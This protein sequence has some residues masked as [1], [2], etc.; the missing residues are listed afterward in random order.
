MKRRAA[1]AIF[2]GRPGIMTVPIRSLKLMEC[3][4]GAVFAVDWP[5]RWMPLVL[6]LGLSC[7]VVGAF[8]LTGVLPLGVGLVLLEAGAAELILGPLLLTRGAWLSIDLER[9]WVHWRRR[10]GQ[11]LLIDSF[12][13]GRLAEVVVSRAPSAVPLVPCWQVAL[14]VDHPR[15]GLVSLGTGW[16]LA[17]ALRLAARVGE[18][19]GLPVTGG[20]GATT[21]TPRIVYQPPSMGIGGAIGDDAP[22]PEIRCRHRPGDG[23]RL[24]LPNM[25]GLTLAGAMFLVYSLLWCLW[26]WIA[27]AFQSFDWAHGIDRGAGQVP[28]LAL[29]SA[30]ALAGAMLLHASVIRLLGEQSLVETP[31]GWRFARRW[32]GMDWGCRRLTPATEGTLRCIT[33]PR[34]HAGLW[35]FDGDR[36]LQLAPG[37]ESD[38]IEWL[39]RQLKSVAP[40][41][42]KQSLAAPVATG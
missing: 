7:C 38:S 12:S 13:P 11:R 3:R 24:L 8:G 17:G 41:E 10:W 22:P 26:S 37:M 14:R 19:L 1:R 36:E 2:R 29:M 25:T 23:R 33:C 16:R 34:D 20:K 42:S 9:G 31:R 4:P 39:A 27:L 32:L 15:L 35:V 6:T 18:A 21:A 40:E 28:A 5:G 30:I